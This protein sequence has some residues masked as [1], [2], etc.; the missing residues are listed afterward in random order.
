[1]ATK[2]R[3]IDTLGEPGLLLPESINNGLAANDRAKYWMSLL[4]MAKARADH[5]D[6]EFS[7]LRREREAAGIGDVRF[8]RVVRDAAIRNNGTYRVPE[9]GEIGTQLTAS[10]RS[11]L[12]PVALAAQIKLAGA[13]A[14]A[15]SCGGR[16]ASLEPELKT[17]GE[18]VEGKVIDAVT[19][20]DRA[21]G[22]SLHILV[23]DL[24]KELN[25]LQRAVA[26]EAIDGAHSYALAAH[27]RPLVRAFMRGVNATSPLKFDHPGLGTT[28]T[29]SEG[30]LVIQNDIGE[31]D[32][33]VVVV[34]V[35]GLEASLIY[36]DVHLERLLFFQSLFENFGVEWEDT[37]SR[38]EAELNRGDVYHL[39]SGHYRAPSATALEE[40]LRFLG[41]RLVF[42]IDWNRA[43]KRLRNF[44]PKRDVLGALRW[45]AQHDFGH[46]AWLRMGGE[47]LIYDAME[48]AIKGPSRFGEQLH[49]MLGA[50][51]ALGYVKFVL[52][53]CSE[54]LVARR[55]ESLIRDEVHAELINYF[56]TVQQDL[57][58]IAEQHACFIVEIA[59]GVRDGLLK[60]PFGADSQSLERGAQRARE[61]EHR[62]DALVN[63]ARLMVQRSDASVFFRKL[64]EASDDV[65]DNLEETAFHL[66]LLEG[67]HDAAEVFKP[68]V[69]LANLLVQGSQEFVKAVATAGHVHRG[70]ERE[71]TQDFL[72]A[73]HRI[74]VIEQRSDDAQRAVKTTLMRA[75]TDSRQI[76]LFAEAARLLEEAADA[77]MH[78]ALIMRDYVLGEAMVN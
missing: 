25:R 35:E 42:L 62:A 68:L 9:A 13:A 10:V 77:L 61:W 72:A 1:M 40:Y 33:H 22:D 29:R 51:K 44:L 20:G 7:D 56:R 49:Q 54:G 6:D 26:G 45:A 14:V 17:S 74:M 34:H 65:A 8:D 3:I 4:Q 67:R 12:A 59:C 5:P 27:D 46:M 60:A 28:A 16:L 38:R 63:Q 2:D 71:D 73:V 41:S 53:T 36:S 47:Q 69:A 11:M 52:K 64:L 18:D 31:T 57:F 39:S 21:H 58:E 32:A 19:S 30:R 37:R 76:Y 24:H 66:T 43:R 78:A 23:M 55:P 75:A 50:D 70:G 48:F 15:E